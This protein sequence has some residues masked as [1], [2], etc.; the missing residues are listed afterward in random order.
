MLPTVTVLHAVARY[1]PVVK[2]IALQNAAF[3]A[4]ERRAY[5]KYIEL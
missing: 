3:W 2:H 4:R 1:S 5:V